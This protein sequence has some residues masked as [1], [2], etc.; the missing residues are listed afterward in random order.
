MV[1]ISKSKRGNRDEFKCLVVSI[2]KTLITLLTWRWRIGDLLVAGLGSYK[3]W[4]IVYPV[5]LCEQMI[6]ST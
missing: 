4:K 6:I 1:F 5:L 2:K 3:I